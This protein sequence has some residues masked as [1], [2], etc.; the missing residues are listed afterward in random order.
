LD[1]QLV[2]TV[3]LVRDAGG[4]ASTAA[5][6]DRVHQAR[7]NDQVALD[8]GVKRSHLVGRPATA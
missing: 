6:D 3:N 7:A 2:A 1:D 5:W 4:S 8:R